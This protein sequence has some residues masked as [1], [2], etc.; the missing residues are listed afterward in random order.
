MENIELIELKNW[1]FNNKSI[2]FNSSDQTDVEIT[3]KYEHLVDKNYD[4]DIIIKNKE[5]SIGYIILYD[6]I[7][8]HIERTKKYSN[9]Y[10]IKYLDNIIPFV[11]L[12]YNN[13]KNELDGYD[14]CFSL[15]P[16]RHKHD[17]EL[18]CFVV[19][20]SWN[21]ITNVDENNKEL[22][23]IYINYLKATYERWS[24]NKKIN[25][26]NEAKIN[27][28]NI[29]NFINDYYDILDS[30]CHNYNDD[31]EDEIKINDLKLKIMK[32]CEN[33]DK[34][35]KYILSISGGVDSMLVSYVLSKLK[36]NF[37][38]VHINYANRKE[39]ENEKK[40]LVEWSNFIGV[41]LYV[42][43]IYEINRK[44][45]MKYQLR[46]LYENYTRNARFQSYID[47]AEMNG[48]NNSDYFIITGHNNDDGVENILTNIVNKTK[49]ENLFGMDYKSTITF[50]NMEL[51]FLRP[52][53][54]ITKI[55]I[56]NYAHHCK[57][58]YLLDT[59]QKWSQR[60]IL[61]NFVTPSLIKWNPLI[62]YGLEQL[63]NNMKEALECVEIL[64]SNFIDKLQPYDTLNINE[65]ISTLNAPQYKIIKL[66]ISEI[67]KNQIF[68]NT[69][70]KKLNI[71]ITSKTLNEFI[72]RIEIFIKNFNKTQ[73]KQLSKIQM[74][75]NNK[76]YYWKINNEY[77][78]FGF[79]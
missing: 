43:D 9:E 35:K 69:F 62:I 58:P 13:Y 34:N 56:Y 51:Y 46:N 32:T 53:L 7:T 33:I 39:C 45:C 41:N 47:V 65:Q 73:I 21:K 1:W 22:I 23:N 36:I 59:T 16:M 24:V 8:R 2:W 3:N 18:Q 52:F 6:Q 38:M 67:K 79:D 76:M 37:L 68:W 28:Y 10:T 11:K 48:W 19:N 55:S 17:F 50:K 66:H 31:N 26:L 12:F 20:E 60:Y 70:F 72:C 25:L 49:Y 61:R 29:L 27:N 74:N 42:R 75:K 5:M 77:A 57:I 71:N 14:F 54:S 63:N 64:V 4:I 78:I 44:K 40:L 30:N 15:L